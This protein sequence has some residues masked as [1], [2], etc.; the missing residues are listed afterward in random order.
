MGED[1]IV[2]FQQVQQQIQVL[3]M[4][5][6]NIQLQKAEVENALS[7][8]EK[9]EEDNVF[10]IVGNV[11]IKKSKKD[12]LTALKEKKELLDLRIS[13]IEKQTEKLNEKAVK[14]QK[15]L[16]ENLKKSKK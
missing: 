4:Q 6:Q 5:K 15:K 8:L 11:M 1:D 16:A 13:T 3:L 10:E 12:V 14:L 9:S 7:E 2:Q